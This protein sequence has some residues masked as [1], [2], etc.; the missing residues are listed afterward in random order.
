MDDTRIWRT[1]IGLRLTKENGKWFEEYCKKENRS[2][3]NAIEYLI[4][5]YK[6]KQNDPRYKMTPDE[7]KELLSGRDPTDHRI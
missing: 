7:A 4:I 2:M 3:S 1:N 6:E 5:K